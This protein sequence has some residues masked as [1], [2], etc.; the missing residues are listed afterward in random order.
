MGKKNFA[1]FYGLYMQ[2]LILFS[3]NWSTNST[4]S[5]QPTYLCL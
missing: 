1:K 4:N 2:R 5:S 3:W